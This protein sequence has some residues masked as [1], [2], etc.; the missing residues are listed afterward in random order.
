[1]PNTALAVALAILVAAIGGFFYGANIEGKAVRGEYAARDLQTATETAAQIKGITT[2]YRDQERAWQEAFGKVDLKLT[3]EIGEHAQTKKK[4]RDAVKSG[5]LVLRDPAANNQ[6]NRN[7]T[8]QTPSGSGGGNGQAGG[9]L[10]VENA[11]VLSEQASEFLIDIASEADQ[12]VLQLTAC[13]RVLESER[14]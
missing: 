4:L 13:Q 6:T 9:K 2:R 12:I 5:T 11:G 1:M 3:A 8:P 7:C 14:Q 10:P